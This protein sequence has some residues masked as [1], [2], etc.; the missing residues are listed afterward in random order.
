MHDLLRQLHH[1]HRP[2]VLL[3]THDVDE[4]IT[5]ADRVVV[6]DHGRIALE[7]RVAL[8]DD[9][10]PSGAEFAQVR[11]HLLGAL[12]VRRTPTQHHT[13]RESA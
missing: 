13:E 10:D 8:D 7:T 5:L 6:L 3:V 1:R 4:A 9:R 11:R 12:G 2:A